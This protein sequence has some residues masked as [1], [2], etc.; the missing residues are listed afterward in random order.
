MEELL[1]FLDGPHAKDSDCFVCIVIHNIDGPGLR[2]LESQQNLA[3]L[4]SCSHVRVVASIDHVN[5]PLLVLTS[6]VLNL[7]T[8][9][10]IMHMH[11]SSSSLSFVLRPTEMLWDFTFSRNVMVGVC[12]VLNGILIFGHLENINNITAN[13]ILSVLTCTSPQ[14]PE[15]LAVE[16]VFRAFSKFFTC[17]FHFFVLLLSLSVGYKALEHHSLHVWD[18]KMVHTQFNWSWYHVPT[19]APYKVEGVFFPLILA[20][21]GTAQNAKTAL[22]VLQSLTPN[23]QSVFKVLAEHQM[24]HSDEEGKCWICRLKMILS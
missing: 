7:V 20:S 9:M 18:K 14:S 3:R 1:T 2:E 15:S 12:L 8:I 11:L 24:A 17:L 21:G 5:A 6:A 10:F 16:R 4:A 19:F 22:I 23:A 13:F